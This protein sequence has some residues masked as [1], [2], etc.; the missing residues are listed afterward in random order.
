MTLLT[1]LNNETNRLLQQLAQEQLIGIVRTDS[2]ES[3]LWAARQ[4]LTAGF[5]FLEVPYT[6]PNCAQVI[7]TLCHEFPDAIIGAGTVLDATQAIHA[8]AAGA[9]FLVAPVIIEPLIQLG[10]EHDVLVLPGCLTPTEIYKAH[11]LGASAIK[12][13][14]AEPSGGAALVQAI[15]GP[16]PHIS[17]V[18]T[19]GINLEHVEGYLRAGVLAVGVGGPLLPKAMVANRDADAIQTRAK[20]YLQVRDARHANA[21]RL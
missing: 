2:E 8:L 16:F 17:L 11:T 1:P 19:G 6:V 14:P 18:A 7:E 15:K 13:F 9:R 10:Q 12:L 5:R 20:E 3:A 21:V 4:V